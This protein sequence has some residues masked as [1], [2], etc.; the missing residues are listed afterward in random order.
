MTEFRG[1]MGLPAKAGGNELFET[2][3]KKLTE[4]DNPSRRKILR[5]VMAANASREKL[6]STWKSRFENG[7]MKC[8]PL[9]EAMDFGIAN[10]FTLEE[11]AKFTNG[12]MDSRLR[13]LILSN[14]YK[15]ILENSEF[16]RLAKKA[17]FDDELEFLLRWRHSTDSVTALEVLTE[18]LRPYA[19]TTLYSETETTIA[20]HTLLDS[21]YF[22][23]ESKFFEQVKRQ[24]KEGTSNSLESFVLL[25]ID[26]LNKDIKDWQEKLD[27][28]SELVDR[29]FDEAPGNFLMVQIAIIATV[30]RAKR[31][32]GTW[33]EDG[34]AATKGLV[35]RLFFARHKCGDVSWWR[36]ELAKIKNETISPCLAILLSWGT[37]DLIA[38]LKTDIDSVIKELSSHDW[39]HLWSMANMVSMA[40]QEYNV[41]FPENRVAISE[42]WFQAAGTLSPRMAFILINRV[43]DQEATCRLSRKY[44]AGYDDNDAQILRDAF[45]TELFGP[46]EYIIDWNYVCHLSE[47]AHKIGVRALFP[48]YYGPQPLK[49]VPEEVAKAVLSDSEN[50]S[51]QL[52][53]MCEQNYATKV[54]QSTAKV[55]Q[56]AEIE[57]WGIFQDK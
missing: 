4:E 13:W 46:D 55:S 30:S 7:L 50:H 12:D 41:D 33:D 54:E 57:G 27:P 47:H 5:V 40:R 14:H 36:T 34:F 19:L 17:F 52:V 24:Y 45:Q 23:G 48:H 20:A 28:W 11:I 38:T 9:R 25:I 49:K 3:E 53:V 8:K 51:R 6:K 26:L 16:Y 18:L 29:G 39:S 21:R 44:F 35:R 22:P 43:D 15:Y 37:P 10:Q 1:D 31:D 2:C 56:V 32:L 42:D